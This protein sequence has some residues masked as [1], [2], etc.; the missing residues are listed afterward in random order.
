M[1]AMMKKFTSH[2][3]VN[4]TMCPGGML[5]AVS[6]CQNQTLVKLC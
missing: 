4:V 1:M 5:N 3:G 6:L 2:P